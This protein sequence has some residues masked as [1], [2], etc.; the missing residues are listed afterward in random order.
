MFLHKLSAYKFLIT[1]SDCK[2]LAVCG[3]IGSEF[4]QIPITKS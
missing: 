1:N 2:I 3:Q 4:D